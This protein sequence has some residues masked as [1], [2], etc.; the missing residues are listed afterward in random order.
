MATPNFW[1]K[2]AEASGQYAVDSV[3][4]LQAKMYD[5]VSGD[6]GVTFNGDELVGDGASGSTIYSNGALVEESSYATTP[7]TTFTLALRFTTSVAQNKTLIC[8]LKDG[9]STQ[10]DVAIV[11][12]YD[13]AN[14]R[15]QPAFHAWRGPPAYAGIVIRITD[16]SRTTKNYNDGIEHSVVIVAN[17]SKTTM[18]IDTCDSYAGETNYVP[19]C[20]DS[21]DYKW[22]IGG[23]ADGL[24]TA[25]AFNGV[26]DDARYW[27]RALTTAEICTFMSGGDPDAKGPANALMFSCNT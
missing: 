8:Y 14:G 26:I 1:F 11:F 15:Y 22:R 12:Y 20:W 6:R 21:N 17:G 3:S 2:F 10:Q 7:P 27:T 18:Y 23:G 5:S 24:A 16:S 4:S 19:E 13:G 25:G 9:G